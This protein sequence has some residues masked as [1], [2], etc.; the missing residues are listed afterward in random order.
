MDVFSVRSV[1]PGVYFAVNISTL[2]LLK[3]NLFGNF[4]KE[5]VF[6]SSNDHGA[7]YS[8]CYF[9]RDGAPPNLNGNVANMPES[10]GHFCQVLREELNVLEDFVFIGPITFE[11]LNNPE[12]NQVYGQ[13]IIDRFVED[14]F[15][16]VDG[17]L[18]PNQNHNPEGFEAVD[19]EEVPHEN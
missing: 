1:Q 19:L 11:L 15:S 13:R 12:Q 4:T 7:F 18:E 9:H 14:G 5:L 6:V 17:V 2:N 3:D 10:A 16:F 8:I